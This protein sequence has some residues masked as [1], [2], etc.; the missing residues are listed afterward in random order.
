MNDVMDYKIQC[1]TPTDYELTMTFHADNKLMLMIFNKAKAKLMKDK[2]IKVN[3]E[4][5]KNISKFE[6]PKNYLKL[7][8]IICKKQ[9]NKIG[10][11]FAKDKIIIMSYELDK[12]IFIRI[13]DRWD[14]KM[15]LS[16]IY[17]DQR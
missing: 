14:I 17:A 16:G 13:Q 5:L 15:C 1:L 6:V 4:G 10:N 9:I 3:D 7:L 12:A 11:I 2:G 8:K